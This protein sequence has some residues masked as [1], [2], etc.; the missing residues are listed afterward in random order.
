MTLNIKVKLESIKGAIAK[1]TVR[2]S[3][4]LCNAYNTQFKFKSFYKNMFII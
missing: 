3:L 2:Y 4:V 1:D